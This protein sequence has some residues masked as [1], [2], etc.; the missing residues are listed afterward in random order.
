MAKAKPIVQFFDDRTQKL[1]QLLPSKTWPALVIS[2]IRMHRY[3]TVDPKEDTVRK[4]KV[5]GKLHGTVMDICTGLG[6][7]AIMAAQQPS[8][9]KVITI[10]KDYNCLKIAGMNDFSKELF[11]N[12]K[13]WSVNN[14]V[15]E[16]IPQ[17]ASESIDFIIHDPPSFSIA[18]ELY[19]LAFYKE[20]FRVLKKRGKFYH[21]VGSPGGKAGKNLPGSVMSRLKEAGF[22]KVRKTEYADGV[23]AEK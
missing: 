23:L 18:G 4:V 8:V 20:L 11:S 3:E 10:E 14:D 13:I 9:E 1:Y 12:K 2:G 5:L 15:L 7:T 17:V 22:T 19:S 21:Y 6:Y 16:F